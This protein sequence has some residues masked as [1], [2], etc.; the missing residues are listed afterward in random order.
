[1]SPVMA[2]EGSLLMEPPPVRPAEPV[3]HV[4]A[5]LRGERDEQALDL[6]AGQRDQAVRGGAAGVFVGKDYREE[7]VGEH[8][9]GDPA[10]PRAVAADL[11]LV[12][13]CQPFLGLEG[14]FHTPPRTSGFDQ[15]SQRDWL[16]GVAA[17]IGEFAGGAVASDQELV[18]ARRRGDEVDDGPV[19]EPLSLRRV[20]SRP[21]AR[22][23]SAPSSP[24]HQ[25]GTSLRPWPFRPSRQR[26][27]HSRCRA[28][29]APRAVSGCRHR[30]RHP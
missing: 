9:E 8:R 26:Q 21:S 10:G 19:V 14:L 3:G 30:P 17:V 29:P 13:S 5:R 4:V 22:P 7:G 18:A 28:P 11:V 12:E 25:R 27:G 16:G 2:G 1:M 24:G 15:R 20:R 23:A 6:V